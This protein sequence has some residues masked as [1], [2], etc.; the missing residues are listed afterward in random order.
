M[1]ARIAN[2]NR[3]KKGML[4]T[5]GVGS[6]LPSITRGDRTLQ[7]KGKR[8]ES[9]HTNSPIP[10]AHP[11]PRTVEIISKDVEPTGR[12]GSIPYSGT[13]S[14]KTPEVR[15]DPNGKKKKEPANRP[16]K[17]EKPK[18]KEVTEGPS[19]LKKCKRSSKI[20][21]SSRSSKQSKSTIAKRKAAADMTKEE[22]FQL[23]SDLTKWWIEAEEELQYPSRKTAEMSAEK[24][25]PDWAIS[26]QSTVL[27]TY[28][29]QD[30]WEI[31]RC[32]LFQHD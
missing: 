1:N 25:V 24:M 19:D 31:Y 18:S 2:R 5:A 26:D 13:P 3:A 6:S 28:E 4:P 27:R 21:R 17:P 15:A 12:I 32:S 11:S 10:L 8:V 23:T 20:S 14:E 29:G 7:S 30:S 16:K 22:N 9:E